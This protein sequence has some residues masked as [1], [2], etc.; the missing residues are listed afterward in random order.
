M[1][2]TPPRDPLTGA[3]EER[4]ASLTAELAEAPEVIEFYADPE[5]YH[6]IL[7]AIDSPAGAF[8]DDFPKDH[9]NSFY[10]RSMPGRRARAFLSSHPEPQET[11]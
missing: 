2:L 10:E 1:P 4:I 7:F 5:T 6:A 8:A 3:M 11:K 9:G